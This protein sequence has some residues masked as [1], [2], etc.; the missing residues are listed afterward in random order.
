MLSVIKKRRSVRSFLSKAV[1][2]EKIEEVLKVASFSPSA[3][4]LKPWQFIVVK[5]VEVRKKLSLASPWGH[6]VAKSPVVIVVCADESISSEWIEDCSVVGAHIYLEVVNQGLG[7]CWVQ[8]RGAK[9]TEGEN[10]E[11]YVK[12]LLDIPKG[13]RV[14]SLF[15]IG[16]PEKIPSSHSETE[17]E[18]RKIH[19]GKW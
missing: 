17:L 11:D 13:F 12:N 14:L 9:T 19:S 15:P 10:A 5:D 4:H 1:E 7:T 3:N 6:F 16:Y 18:R 8:I 2:D